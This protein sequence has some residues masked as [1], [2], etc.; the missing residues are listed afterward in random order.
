MRIPSCMADRNG[1]LAL[2]RFLV[3]SGTLTNDVVQTA[4]AQLPNLS[5][6]KTLIDWLR[7]KGAI[8]EEELAKSLANKLHLPLV[9]LPTVA[10]DS[11]ISTLLKE[12]LAMQ[13]KVVPTRL[14]GQTLMVAMANPLDHAAIRAIEFSTGKRVQ[15][16][17]ATQT[18]VRDAID[19]LYH[20]DEALDTYLKGIPEEGDTPISELLESSATNI[21]SLERNST[22]A[23]VV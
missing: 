22:L 3:R 6:G 8:D 5:N 2:L 4:E 16:G 7:E 19:H 20:L 21:R 10:M 13:Y 1:N 14:D 17:V 11:S 15:A 12:D 9:D 18:A 23:P